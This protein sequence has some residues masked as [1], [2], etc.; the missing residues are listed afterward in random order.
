MLVRYLGGDRLVPSLQV[1]VMNCGV[2]GQGWRETK[3]RNGLNYFLIQKSDQLQR[4]LP[5]KS[6]LEV[7]FSVLVKAK[8]RTVPKLAN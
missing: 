4:L 3:R 7:V 1:A 5:P 8:D 6:K 2:G